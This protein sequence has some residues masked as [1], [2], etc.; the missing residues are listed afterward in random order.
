MLDLGVQPLPPAQYYVRKSNVI[1]Q[2]QVFLF[3]AFRIAYHLHLGV[4]RHMN[5]RFVE[6]GTPALG[7]LYTDI[8]KI[9]AVKTSWLRFYSRVWTLSLG[10]PQVCEPIMFKPTLTWTLSQKPCCKHS[11]GRR[12]FDVLTTLGTSIVPACLGSSGALVDQSSFAPFADH[13]TTPRVRELYRPQQLGLFGCF[14]MF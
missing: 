9:C 6:D 2:R 14:A 10:T 11:R 3:D 1:L 7:N 4:R 5:D 8:I 12:L 13:E